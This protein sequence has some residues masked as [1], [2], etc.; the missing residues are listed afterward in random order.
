MKYKEIG[1]ASQSG[2]KKTKKIT[3]ER[4]MERGKQEHV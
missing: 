3:F 4:K 1:V 2:I